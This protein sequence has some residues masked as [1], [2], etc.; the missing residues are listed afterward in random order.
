MEIERRAMT[1]GT[2]SIPPI[3]I[4]DTE[5]RVARQTT[6]ADWLDARAITMPMLTAAL[7]G[8]DRFGVLDALA[9]ELGVSAESLPKAA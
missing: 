5:L 3:A 4:L 8:D 1:S 9:D 6:L 2:H 7:A